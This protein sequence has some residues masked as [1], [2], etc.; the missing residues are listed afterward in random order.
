MPQVSFH[1]L[2]LRKQNICLHYCLVKPKNFSDKEKYPLFVYLHGFS[3]DIHSLVNRYLDLFT[4]QNYF[5]VFPQGVH[6]VLVDGRQ[7]YSWYR[8]NDEQYMMKDIKRD[9]DIVITLCDYLKR[10]LSVCREHVV[11]GGFSQGAKLSHYIGLRHYSAFH[12][13]IPV[14]GTYFDNEEHNLLS[15]ACNLNVHLFHGTHDELHP[16]EEAQSVYMQFVDAQVPVTFD[17]YDLG[18]Y[19]NEEIVKKILDRVEE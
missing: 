19:L 12:S 15:K 18:H 1:E 16:F 14:S 13:L 8:K 5:I 7:G 11:L 4:S 2:Y 17:S 9:E 10:S 6:E 3:D